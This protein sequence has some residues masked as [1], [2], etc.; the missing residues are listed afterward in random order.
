M[1]D[2]SFRKR[3]MNASFPDIKKQAARIY[4]ENLNHTITSTV[5]LSQDV[6]CRVHVY[7]KGAT[8]HPFVVFTQT[9]SDTLVLWSLAGS[10][11]LSVSVISLSSLIQKLIRA[12]HGDR[13]RNSAGEKEEDEEKK[14]KRVRRG[15]KSIKRERLIWSP[16][17][18]HSMGHYGSRGECECTGLLQIH[19][20]CLY[21]ICSNMPHD[22]KE[23]QENRDQKAIVDKSPQ[24][25]GELGTE[26]LFLLMKV[27]FQ[28]L[29]LSREVPLSASRGKHLSELRRRCIHSVSVFWMS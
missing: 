22:I 29:L 24:E 19:W 27:G 18:S 15:R 16:T 4:N 7:R 6:L 8:L 11:I 10:L 1:A 25:P 5:H 3:F 12:E 26:R 23:S 28:I 20:W 13:W 2:S 17:V 21:T 14:Q 9:H